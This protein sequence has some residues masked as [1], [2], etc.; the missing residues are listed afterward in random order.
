MHV[1]LL[2]LCGYEEY[3]NIAHFWVGYVWEKGRDGL[4]IASL[5]LMCWHIFSAVLKGYPQKS[6]FLELDWYEL[7][8]QCVTIV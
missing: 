1:Q 7:E 5:R 3:H 2:N 4:L 6:V 8:E